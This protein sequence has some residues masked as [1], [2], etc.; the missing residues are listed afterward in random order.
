M[1]NHK[2]ELKRN[3]YREKNDKW[4]RKNNTEKKKCYVSQNKNF[5]CH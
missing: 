2:A 5:I 1:A 3:A 4:N